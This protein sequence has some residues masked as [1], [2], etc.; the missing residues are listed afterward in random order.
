MFNTIILL[1]NT[2]RL[3]RREYKKFNKGDLII[4]NDCFPEKL[5]IWSIEQKELAKAELAKH[6]CKYK[7]Y[8]DEL[9]EIEEYALEY[10]EYDEDGEFVEGSDYDFA[11]ER[12]IDLRELRL[13]CGMN[14]REF[15]EY[16]NIPLRS[17]EN[18]ES[19]QREC[20]AYLLELI[21]YKLEK[22]GLI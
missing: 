12:G 18:W 19:K 22:E 11:E 2:A 16:F 6:F 3:T 14:R 9:I 20:P 4:G 10:C 5:R 8:N 7:K 15:A 1:K 17:I 21:K 13:D